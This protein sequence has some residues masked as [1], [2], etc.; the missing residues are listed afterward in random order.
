METAKIVVDIAANE[1]GS[2]QTLSRSR[3]VG[4]L[5]TRLSLCRSTKY[6]R[7]KQEETSTGL[8]FSICNS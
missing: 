2:F 5:G 3:G 4:G 7:R 8:G 6:D 1:N